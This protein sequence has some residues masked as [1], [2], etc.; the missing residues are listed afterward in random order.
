V[1]IAPDGS[2]YRIKEADGQYYYVGSRYLSGYVPGQPSN[3]SNPGGDQP[4]QPAVNFTNLAE[5]V[6]MYAINKTGGVRVYAT[7]DILTAAIT[8]LAADFPVEC[9]AI[10][11]DQTWYKVRLANQPNEY[12]YV[13]VSDVQ[14]GG[15]G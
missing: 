15:K 13:Q 5:P 2:W 4:A 14:T 11:T 8:T 6:L 3:P 9:V 10:S 7:P 12:F 1:A